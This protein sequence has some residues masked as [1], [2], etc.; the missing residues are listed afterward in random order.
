MDMWEPYRAAID[1][2]F[3]IPQP[4]VVHDR[5]HIVSHAN[6]VMSHVRKDE[7]R[8]RAR[9]ARSHHCPVEGQRP[10][11]GQGLRPQGEPS[12]LLASPTGDHGA[13]PLSVLDP[14]GELVH[15]ATL[16]H[17]NRDDR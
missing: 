13:K 14:V 11:Y 9:A 16:S 7:V 6:D 5:F 15:P 17:G 2:V 12:L 4:D 1:A 8:K 3:S 10:A